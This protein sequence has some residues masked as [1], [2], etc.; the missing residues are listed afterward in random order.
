MRAM[1]VVM[2]AL[3]AAFLAIKAM[4]YLVATAV[5]LTAVCVLKP[6]WMISAI[7]YTAKKFL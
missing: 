4:P 3:A 1:L 2:V 7:T 5:L 6:K